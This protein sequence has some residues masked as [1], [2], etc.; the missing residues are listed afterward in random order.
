[1]ETRNIALTL[2]K[3]REWYNSGS[4]DLKEVALQAYTEEEL[5]LPEWKNI[6]TFE[7]ACRAINLDLIQVRY[8]FSKFEGLGGNLGNHLRA[9]YKLDI[10]RKAL[11]KGWNLK[12]TEGNVYY[13]Y[14]QFYPTSDKVKEAARNNDGEVKKTFK[15]D[16]KGY[17]L[18]GGGCRLSY[19]LGMGGFNSGSGDT[20]ACVGLLGCKSKEIAKHMSRYFA[21]EI[22]EACYAHHVE[23]Y[24]WIV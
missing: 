2:E 20:C 9:I 21:K 11:N 18:V 6:K 3:A 1:M 8:D 5:K 19:G 16:G 17:F 7:N 10:I 13:P 23:I 24:E 14:V 22:F 4:S 12:M 15:A